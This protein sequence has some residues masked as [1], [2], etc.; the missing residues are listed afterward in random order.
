VS[1]FPFV[2]LRIVSVCYFTVTIMEPYFVI[3]PLL[4]EELFRQITKAKEK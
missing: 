1:F 2:G 3:F 4:L